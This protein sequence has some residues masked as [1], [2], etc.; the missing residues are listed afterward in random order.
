MRYPKTLIMPPTPFE[1]RMAQFGRSFPPPPT[2]PLHDILVTRAKF[3]AE[4]DISF[5][6][7]LKEA[8][9]KLPSFILA[10]M[11]GGTQLPMANA[12]REYFQEY[13]SRIL[14][15]GAHSFPASF[16]VVESF[17]HFSHEHFIFDLRDEEE[18]LLRLHDFFEWFTSGVGLDAPAILTEV[19]PEGKI[20]IYNVVT[21]LNDFRL[22]TDD[23]ELVISGVALVRHDSELSMIALCGE[24]P[25]FPV[26]DELS[27]IDEYEPVLGKENLKR[28]P[29]Y[30]PEDRYLKEVPGYSKVLALVRFDLIGRRYYV[31]YLCRDVGP[32]YLTS[33]DDPLIFLRTGIGQQERKDILAASSKIL[34][35]YSPLFSSL[36]TLLYLPVFFVEERGRVVE[37]VF[38]TELHS[39]KR[40][41][42]VRRAVRDLSRDTLSF[43]RKVFCMESL[44][45]D[46]LDEERIVVPPDFQATSAGLWRNLP[47]GEIGED[48]HGN[49][50]VGRTWVER[51]ETWSQRS[52]ERFVLRKYQKRM[53][54]TNPGYLYLMRSGTHSTDIYKIGKTKRSAEFRA[55]ELSGATGVPTKFEVLYTWEVEDVDVLEKEVHR[56]LSPYRISKRREFFRCSPQVIIRAVN[57]L[58]DDFEKRKLNVG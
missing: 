21:P 31:R 11:M 7:W 45:S 23:S 37:T 40:S 5:R 28:D 4:H 26:A 17:L 54:G 58:V 32:S 47:A 15:H 53:T 19:L 20:Y 18:H 49:P 55:T 29:G 24:F 30:S 39:R 35:R 48:E 52:V 2:H 10:R 46:E 41:T 51:T 12:L 8:E 14:N 27:G 22:Q 13:A 42:R 6:L 57:S 50:I 38:S 56:M 33:T 44:F 43:T 3:R 16:N 1:R 36:A 34:E 9:K 25:E